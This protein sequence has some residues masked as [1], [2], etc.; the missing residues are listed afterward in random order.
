MVFPGYEL[1]SILP[2]H[3]WFNG[4][5]YTDGKELK[6]AN[7]PASAGKNAHPQA[8]G[9]TPEE[10]RQAFAT[11]GQ[12]YHEIIAILISSHLSQAVA[13]AQE[14]IE[15]GQGPAS[16]HLIDSQTTA[17]GLGLL[18]QVA[19]R[20]AQNGETG[21]R[22]NRLIRGIIPRIYSVFCVQN[23]TYLYCSGHLD[24]AQAIVGEMLGVTPFF[25]LENGR[26]VP[27]QKVRN[28]R[29]LVDILHEFIAEF[30]DLKHIAVVQ[31]V[32]PFEQEVRNLK[33]RLDGNFPRVTF[34]E[35]TLGTALAAILGPRSLGVFAMESCPDF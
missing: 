34:S 33:D 20:A 31:G 21:A 27:V 12:K 14:A 15:T 11:L 22:I 5:E 6:T 13:S 19:A 7:L 24:P 16:V 9:P 23:L 1:V 4:Q 17:V 28:S 30:S 18:V 26:L 32:P 10:F 25:V 2:M 35:H 3:V 8:L 29:H